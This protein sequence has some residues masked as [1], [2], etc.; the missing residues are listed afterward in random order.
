MKKCSI[1]KFLHEEFYERKWED[2]HST[3]D[4]CFTCGKYEALNNK[5]FKYL[6]KNDN[7]YNW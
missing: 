1:C 2:N 7:E 6:D 3:Y 4:T 5:S